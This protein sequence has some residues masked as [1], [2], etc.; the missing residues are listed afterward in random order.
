MV[1]LF[2]F[3]ALASAPM[4]DIRI[5]ATALGAAVLLD[6]TVVRRSLR[7]PPEAVARGRR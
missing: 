5:M 7:I 3:A 2:A 1:G 4:A 6:T